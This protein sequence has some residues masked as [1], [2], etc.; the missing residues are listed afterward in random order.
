VVSILPQLL[1]NDFGFV[2]R[3]GWI[4]LKRSFQHSAQMLRALSPG[5]R[6]VIMKVTLVPRSGLHLE[7]CKTSPEGWLRR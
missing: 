4:M 1:F 3:W 5:K 6:P 7:F 2:K